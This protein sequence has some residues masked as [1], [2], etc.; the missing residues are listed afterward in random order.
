MPDFA[1]H[2]SFRT[3]CATL[4]MAGSLATQGCI[5]GG[6]KKPPKPFIPPPVYAKVPE[7]VQAT[8][9]DVPALPDDHATEPGVEPVLAGSAANLPPAPPKPLPPKAPA[10]KPPATVVEVT[11]TPTPV[12]P[13]PQP[14]AIFSNAER[15]RMNQ[16][17]DQSLGKVRAALARA[18][19][20]SL[21][22]D[23]AALVNSARAMMQ[24]AE[25][26]RLQDPVTA[27]SLAK[28]AET[29]ATD[30]AQQLSQR[31]Q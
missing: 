24:S 15:Q 16:E 12:A 25:S 9:V 8:V 6:G 27:V 1:H 18:E 30:L 22:A 23:L 20:K 17:I 7:P 13:A 26:A 21:S 4:A 3:A 28:R 2:S 19:G 11:P 14:A 29:F 10:P 5:F 31:G